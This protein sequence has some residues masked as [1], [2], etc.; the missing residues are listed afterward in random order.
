MEQ[1]LPCS[2][3]CRLQVLL[4][5]PSLL[6]QQSTWWVM[7]EPTLGQRLLPLGWWTGLWFAQVSLLEIR[8]RRAL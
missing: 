5:Y 2:R 6:V 3:S 8:S 1:R 7:L 4:R